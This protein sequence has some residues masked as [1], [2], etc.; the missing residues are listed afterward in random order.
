[1]QPLPYLNQPYSTN[2]SLSSA[3]GFLNRP[4]AICLS[5]WVGRPK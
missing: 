1:M 3:N 2:A 4:T 5:N